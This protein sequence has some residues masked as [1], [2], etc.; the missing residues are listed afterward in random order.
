MTNKNIYIL[1]ELQGAALSEQSAEILSAIQRI[2]KDSTITAIVPQAKEEQV[3]KLPVD[4]VYYGG[5]DYPLLAGLWAKAAACLADADL[6]ITSMSVNGRDFG[7]AYAAEK[8][9]TYVPAICDL[10]F[11]EEETLLKRITYGGLAQEETTVDAPFVL[12]LA[13]GVWGYGTPGNGNPELKTLPQVKADHQTKIE[14]ERTYIADWQEMEINEGDM[15]VAGG[16]GMG[17]T[18]NFNQ[19][20]QL[21]AALQAPVGGS[22]IAEDKGWIDHRQ[23]IG[24]TGTTIAPKLYIACGISGAVQHTIG[25]Q[26]SRYIIAINQ[27]QT[28]AMMTGSDLAVQSD[29]P[30]TILE[31]SKLLKDY[32]PVKEG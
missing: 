23:M 9:I 30:A 31:L 16:M 27:D 32:S 3:M 5:S 26:G 20:Y 13:P 19:L 11:I 8:N 21:G 15:V 25:I 14:I 24:A 28:A 18:E 6:V 7:A 17:N 22:R 1:L 29:A 4:T 12:G 2:A 10:E